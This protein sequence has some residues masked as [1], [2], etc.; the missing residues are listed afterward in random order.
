MAALSATNGTS[1]SAKPFA[2]LVADAAT[3]SARIAM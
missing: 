1:S 2:M 3:A